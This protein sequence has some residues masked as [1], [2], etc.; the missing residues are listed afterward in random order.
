MNTSLQLVNDCV[1][2]LHLTFLRANEYS[3]KMLFHAEQVSVQADGGLAGDDYVCE[4]DHTKP[5][6]PFAWFGWIRPATTF[7]QIDEK[8][9]TA[10]VK[11]RF[12]F[13]IEVMTYLFT[14]ARP[15]VFDD[16]IE[17]L[18]ASYTAPLLAVYPL[19]YALQVSLKAEH[20]DFR[21]DG[22]YESYFCK[23]TTARDAELTAL[24]PWLRHFAKRLDSIGGY[25]EFLILVK[26]LEF[27]LKHIDRIHHYDFNQH[28]VLLAMAGDFSALLNHLKKP[29]KVKSG[30]EAG[31]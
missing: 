4:V 14:H 3:I 12:T 30:A 27:I 25:K 6:I 10:E 15:T 17:E 28:K 8:V 24:L 18:S 13:P 7:E 11:S 31:M 26:Q 2:A 9:Y 19:D 5:H 20:K 22:Y 16:P 29:V 21:I 23:G 1:A